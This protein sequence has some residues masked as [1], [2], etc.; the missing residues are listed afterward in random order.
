MPPPSTIPASHTSRM[1]YPPR[2]VTS[3][4]YIITGRKA[5]ISTSTR[6]TPSKYAGF[7]PITQTNSALKK[8]FPGDDDD[9]ELASDDQLMPP[10]SAGPSIEETTLESDTSLH[11]TAHDDSS[12]HGSKRHSP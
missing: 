11:M 10:S 4:N 7:K 2:D 9:M 6:F 5:D 1:T 8:F 3:S 12:Q